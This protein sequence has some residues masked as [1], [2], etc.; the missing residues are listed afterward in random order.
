MATNDSNPDAGRGADDQP[1][2]PLP[3]TQPAS[4]QDPDH[5]S[6]STTAPAPSADA[7]T[8]KADGERRLVIPSANRVVTTVSKSVRSGVD[9][10]VGTLM[11]RGEAKALPTQTGVIAPIHRPAEGTLTGVTN[12]LD[13]LRS[14]ARPLLVGID[15]NFRTLCD[16]A[17]SFEVTLAVG[18]EHA[19]EVDELL[20][21]LPAVIAEPRAKGL[22]APR[23]YTVSVTADAD[24]QAERSETLRELRVRTGEP[25]HSIARDEPDFVAFSAPEPWLD[26]VRDALTD[27]A[28]VLCGL[29]WDKPAI[30]VV[31]F[32]FETTHDD[33]HGPTTDDDDGEES[34]ASKPATGSGSSPGSPNAGSS[35][36]SS[37]GAGAETPQAGS[38]G[39]D[40][41]GSAGGPY[42][43][44]G[45][46]AST[47][48]DTAGEKAATGG[49]A[50]TSETPS[51][52]TP[53]PDGASP[54]VGNDDDDPSTDAVS[55]SAPTSDSGHD[56]ESDSDREPP[57]PEAE[58]TPESDGADEE[59]SADSPESAGGGSDGEEPTP[60]GA[61]GSASITPPS[62]SPA[63]ESDTP[64]GG[65]AT[66]RGAGSESGG[67][68]NASGADDDADKSSSGGGTPAGGEAT[69]VG[70]DSQHPGAGSESAPDGP[71]PSADSEQTPEGA[72]TPGGPF[73][74]ATPQGDESAHNQSTGADGE[75]SLQPPSD[76]SGGGNS[77][78]STPPGGP[79]GGRGDDEAPERRGAEAAPGGSPDPRPRPEGGSDSASTSPVDSLPNPGPLTPSSDG[80]ATDESMAPSKGLDPDLDPSGGG[81]VPAPP[82]TDA[83]TSGDPDAVD[84]TEHVLNEIA[85]HATAH[86]DTEVYGTIY[87][88]ED[89]LIRYHHPVDSETYL[90][91]RKRAISFKPPFYNHLEELARVHKDID[92]R[93]S[94][95]V[96]SHPK[97]GVPLQSAADKRFAKRVWKTQRNTVFIV[98]LDSGGGPEEW[99]VTADGYEAQRASNGHLVR[100][101]AFSGQNEPK[102]I[103]V[104]CD[105]GG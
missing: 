60:N 5:G 11:R 15:H 63:P 12:E 91:R 26:P 88:N 104:H 103:R 74:S 87:A 33:S 76:A 59:E 86:P 13:V 52:H 75:A 22:G 24:D 68:P 10:L 82:G 46:S 2:Q 36:S 32:V 50:A 61:A 1:Q 64:S 73:A 90:K 40:A 99:T 19:H 37:G 6:A 72:G 28:P 95:D 21:Y 49:E 54:P 23:S 85:T 66:P 62:S 31:G 105:M 53:G 67:D 18:S 83:E 96:H 58:S 69:P 42:S 65:G 92:H 20:P 25:L 79:P 51:E 97:S 101:R 71:Q 35:E 80:P 27:W 3:D 55:S 14:D 4:D 89:G 41:R 7:E 38:G 39:P 56:D 48:G 17:E 77:S 94:G 57:A 100:V 9:E 44:G 98:G 30:H 78:G 84:I 45:S 8:G 29:S 34:A 16:V 47:S 81:V 93:L 102:E 43:G 70:T